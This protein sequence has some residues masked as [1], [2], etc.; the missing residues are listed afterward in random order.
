MITSWKVFQMTET[1]TSQ[2]SW[3]LSSGTFLT[4]SF[5]PLNISVTLIKKTV[6]WFSV[7]IDWLVSIWGQLHKK[8]PPALSL[9]TYMAILR[10]YAA[11]I[12]WKI[13]ER[14]HASIAIKLK[15][16]ILCPFLCL[17]LK[18]SQSKSFFKINTRF[19]VFMLLQI[20]TKK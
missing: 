3:H 7:Q 5:N 4:H 9:K 8:D 18:K 16:F 2:S 11:V 17:L 15:Y 13:L 12:S 1:V 10:F 14:Y 19:S 20:H 6:N